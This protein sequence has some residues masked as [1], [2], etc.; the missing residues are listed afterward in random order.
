[1]SN[2]VSNRWLEY[3]QWKTELLDFDQVSL[4]VI[5]ALKQ[6]VLKKWKCIHLKQ[7]HININCKVSQKSLYMLYFA[8]FVLIASSLH[9]FFYFCSWSNFPFPR[10]LCPSFTTYLPIIIIKR[11]F[12][13]HLLKSLYSFISSTE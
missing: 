12:M 2:T 10:I 5:S 4:Q 1:M 13:S 8:A 3:V 7:T 9:Y 6:A 11:G